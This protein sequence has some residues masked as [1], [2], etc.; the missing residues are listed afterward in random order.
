MAIGLTRTLAAMAASLALLPIPGADAATM[1]RA[2]FVFD[3]LATCVQPALQNFPV[4]VEGTGELSTDRTATLS[5]DSSIGGRENYA[6]KLGGKPSEAPGGSASVRVVSRHTLQAVR[7]Y[8]NNRVLVYMTV[9]GN[10]CALRVENRLKPGK[11][12]YTFTGNM[13]VAL[14]A[15]P[16]IVHTECTPY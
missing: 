13:G 14:C 7:E 12:Q 11:R 10:S 8:P 3:G 2:K 6:G 15:K 4:H 1:I 9:I 5:L 16:R